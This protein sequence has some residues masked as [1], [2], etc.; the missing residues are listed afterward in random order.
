LTRASSDDLVARFG[1]QVRRLPLDMAQERERRIM[2]IRHD[3]E[4]DLVESGLDLRSI[5]KGELHTL[6]ESLVP[7]P[8]AR[9]L[10][11]LVSE[12]SPSR[13]TAPV[14]FQFNQIVS[15]V[16]GIVMQ[17]VQGVGS[18][19][20]EAKEV[21]A[22]IDRVAGSSAAT[23]RSDVLELEDP[24]APTE[25]RLAAQRRLRKFISQLAGAVRDVGVDLISG[26]LEH[27]G[28]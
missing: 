12:R 17:Q 5:P 6:I 22:F 10:L 7:R 11:A 20:L 8:N 25:S 27:K 18:L 9:E 14:V 13:T 4:A 2:A 3:F 1:R 24:A 23:L 16:E 15:D 26:Y 19:G 21:L 28:L